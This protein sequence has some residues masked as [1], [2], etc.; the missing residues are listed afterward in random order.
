VAT[1]E[2][3]S[4]LALSEAQRRK[5]AEELE[6]LEKRPVSLNYRVDPELVA[7]LSLKKGN[8]V[9]DASFRGYLSKLKEKIIEG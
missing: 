7:G 2:V 9:Y 1:F 4:V 6:R 8:L 3:S 5:L